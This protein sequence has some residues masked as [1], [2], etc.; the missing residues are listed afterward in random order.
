ML[1]QW[2]AFPSL[3]G[4]NYWCYPKPSLR[5]AIVSTP[6]R[7]KAPA[8]TGR[9]KGHKGVSYGLEQFALNAPRGGGGQYGDSILAFVDEL[10]YF[11]FS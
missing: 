8:Y 1:P 9:N 2:K 7:H 11:G 5:L 6:T 3:P 4:L 10:L